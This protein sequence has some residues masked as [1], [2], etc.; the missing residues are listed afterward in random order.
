VEGGHD[1]PRDLLN[2][3]EDTLSQLSQLAAEFEPGE[4]KTRKQAGQELTYISIDATINRLNSVLGSTWSTEAETSLTPLGE[5]YLAKCELTLFA[6]IDDE[7]KSAYGVG[8]MVNKDPDMAA[9]TALAEAIKKA[10]HQL[11][12]GLYLWDAEARDR[13]TKKSKLA[14]ASAAALK[15]EVFKLAVAKTGKERPSAKDIA[16]VFGK[17]ATDLAD[18]TTLIEILKGEGLL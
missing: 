14:G 8:A 2:F 6:T 3:T 9:K 17:T 13:V 10:G 11:G 12:I 18:E 7:R 4:H 5:T 15:Q 1:T 16:A